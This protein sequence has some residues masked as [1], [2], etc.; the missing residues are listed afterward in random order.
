MIGSQMPQD[1]VHKY[2]AAI[3]DA[4]QSLRN[5]HQNIK[6]RGYTLNI[7]L[8]GSLEGGRLRNTFP[9]LS[10]VSRM[11]S[12]HPPATV[13]LCTSGLWASGYSAR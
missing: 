3:V 9:I 4:L 8:H 12:G 7:G 13:P 1:Y 10:K 2:G 5:Y 11:A 6:Y